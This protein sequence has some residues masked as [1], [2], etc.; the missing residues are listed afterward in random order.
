MSRAATDAVAR[1]APDWQGAFRTQQASLLPGYED[2]N[3]FFAVP[4]SAR[5]AE[6][7][8]H[9]PDFILE[10]VSDRNDASP[11]QSLYAVIR[12]GLHWGDSIGEAYDVLKQRQPGAVMMPAMF[13]TGTVWHLQCRELYQT[14]PFAWEDARRA[15]IHCRIGAQ[16]ANLLYASLEGGTLPLARVALECQIAAFLPRIESTVSFEPASLLQALA[17]LNP[18]GRSVPFRRMLTFFGEFPP[19]LLRF[20]G[21]DE[22]APGRSR[23]LALA[24]RVCHAF[25][26]PAAC[27]SLSDGPHVAFRPL[28]DN[29]QHPVS[30]DLRTPLL[31]AIPTFLDFDPFTRIVQNGERDSVTRFTRVPP[32]PEDMLTERVAVASGLPARIQN[33]M[34][35]ELTLKVEKDDAL[36]GNLTSEVVTLYPPASQTTTV[37]LSFR[38]RGEKPYSS[39]ITVVFEDGSTIGTPW[40]PGRGDY[41]YIG[42]DQLPAY[43]LAVRAT[44]SLLAEGRLSLALTGLEEEAGAVLTEQEPAVAFLL[45]DRHARDRARLVI[46]VQG[47]G[48]NERLTLDLPCQSVSLDLSAFPQYGPR[49]TPVTVR[50]HD[51]VQAAQFAFLPEGDESPILLAFSPSQPHGQFSYFSSRLFRNRYRFRQQ[52]GEAPGQNAWSDYQQAGLPLIISAY[53]GPPEN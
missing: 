33:C 52:S 51:G 48:D 10:F 39:R 47:P 50:F 28:P 53:P 36:S 8:D 24:G 38:K 15:S 9:T 42:P 49:Q 21:D 37:E 1:G 46:T 22:G 23:A 6:R 30:W 34:A 35:V 14:A 20:D 44:P 45:A 26:E 40:R 32:L 5:L 17:T 41:L 43:C 3:L 27:P 4:Q 19:G 18:G 12:M 29:G 31:V 13:P 2:E 16:I 25:A 11:D 7:D